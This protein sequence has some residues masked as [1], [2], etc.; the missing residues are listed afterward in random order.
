MRGAKKP[1]KVTVTP[2]TTL[3][4]RAAATKGAYISDLYSPTIF[5][6]T[7]TFND[8]GSI[9]TTIANNAVYTKGEHDARVESARLSVHAILN[10]HGF[11]F[12][13]FS[14]DGEDYTMISWRKHD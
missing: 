3:E 8:P 1:A 7:A 11:T 4:E 10:A 5:S 9:S 6:H 14:S 12:E 13:T 2:L